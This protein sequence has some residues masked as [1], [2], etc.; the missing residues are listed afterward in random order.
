MAR[1]H[2][3][4]DSGPSVSRLAYFGGLG[5]GILTAVFAYY[6]VPAL[7]FGTLGTAMIELGAMIVAVC[8]TK[9][10]WKISDWVHH[11]DRNSTPN[12]G[13]DI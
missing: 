3:T 6:Q 1:R 8:V 7:G 5:L 12:D 9:A 2:A 13:S 11:L 4:D 10:V